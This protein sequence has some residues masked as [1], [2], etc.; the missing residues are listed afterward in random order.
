[1]GRIVGEGND[2]SKRRLYGN[3]V[4][5]VLLYSAETLGLAVGFAIGIS[6]YAVNPMMMVAC[7]FNRFGRGNF[8]QD[9]GDVPELRTSRTF[10]CFNLNV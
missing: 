2:L 6:L 7:S 4:F 5:D 8:A 3:F 10:G 1:M 9:F